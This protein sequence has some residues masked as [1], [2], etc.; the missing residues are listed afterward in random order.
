MG[1]R[2]CQL[3]MASQFISL[4]IMVIVCGINE[5]GIKKL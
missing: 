2:F 4:G 5:G 3:M 1:K